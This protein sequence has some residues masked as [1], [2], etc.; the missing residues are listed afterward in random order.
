VNPFDLRGPEFLAFYVAL[1]AVA[2]L[3]VYGWW[4]AGDTVGRWA[5]L[6]SDAVDL[7][8]LRGGRLEALRVTLLRFFFENAISFDGRVIVPAAEPPKRP[9]APFE[10]ELWSDLARPRTLAG[11]ASEGASSLACGEIRGRFEA[12]GYLRP[13]ASQKRGQRVVT[14]VVAA[15]LAVGAI[16]FA[17]ALSRGH[18]NLLF[19]I[20]LMIAV[21]IV[22]QRARMSP[23]TAR[24]RSA[25]EGAQALLERARQSFKDSATLP[26]DEELVMLAAAFG[27]SAVSIQGVP[28]MAA[29]NG[30]PQS[31]VATGSWGGSSSCSSTSSTCGSSS[32]CSSSSC[33]SSC[34]GG[35]GGGGCGG[36]SS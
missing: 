10:A 33:G 7:A 26:R 25:L 30:G 31:A 36:C 1:A 27:L 32:S 19:L 24:G 17:I 12:L 22:G 15:L 14:F 3:A 28:F 35:C 6:P 16:K 2:A 20:L 5:E 11:L 4:Q 18:K 34:G 13:E 9:L 23:L 29:L 21:V 8:Y